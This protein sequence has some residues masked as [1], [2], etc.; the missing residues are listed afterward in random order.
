MVKSNTKAPAPAAAPSGQM[1][2]LNNLGY[3]AGK[4]TTG[5]LMDQKK[6]IPDPESAK[7]KSAVEEFQCD[8]MPPGSVDGKCGP[9]TQAKLEKVHGC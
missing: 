8:H 4:L 9:Q 6:D 3:F 7:F 5:D 2:R 1:A